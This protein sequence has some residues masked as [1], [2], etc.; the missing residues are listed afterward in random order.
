M[1][2]RTGD[3][4]IPAP[5]YGRLM[6]QFTVNLIVRDVPRSLAFYQAPH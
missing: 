1:K 3:P 2:L 6:P 5:E 4:C